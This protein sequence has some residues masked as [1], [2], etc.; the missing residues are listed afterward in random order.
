MVLYRCKAVVGEA[1]HCI[2]RSDTEAAPPPPPAP[3]FGTICFAESQ[4]HTF[5]RMLQGNW[6]QQGLW[7]LALYFLMHMPVR[8][9]KAGEGGG[10]CMVFKGE[11]EEGGGGGIDSYCGTVVSISCCRSVLQ[12]PIGIPGEVN[13]FLPNPLAPPPTTPCVEPCSRAH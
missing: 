7:H 3:R 5:L 4:S 11:E 13:P 2:K 1:L 12:N 6:C 8:T 10:G 9:G